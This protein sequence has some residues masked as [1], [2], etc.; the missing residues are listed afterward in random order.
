LAELFVESFTRPIYIRISKHVENIEKGTE[1]S[2]Q[3]WPEILALVSPMELKIGELF[4][5]SEILENRKPKQMPISVTGQMDNIFETRIE[6]LSIPE[7]TA[8]GIITS[9]RR[10]LI[11]V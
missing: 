11:K 6:Y 1:S 2:N 10:V 3:F 5:K 7:M 4:Q 9:I 8:N